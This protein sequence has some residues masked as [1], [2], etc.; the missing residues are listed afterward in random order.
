MEW[1]VRPMVGQTVALSESMKVE[2][3][4]EL[5][6]ASSAVWMVV[7]MELLAPW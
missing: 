2:T 5:V 6:A 4:D 1:R 7:A 3:M